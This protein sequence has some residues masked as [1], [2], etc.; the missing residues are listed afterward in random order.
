MTK[1]F[2]NLTSG[3]LSQTRRLDVVGNNMVNV[4]TP[5]YKAET[6]TDI[7]FEDV[8]ISRIGNANK[9]ESEVI[10]SQSY[11]LASDQLYVDMQNSGFELTGLNLD[12]ALLGDGFFG[13]QTQDGTEYTRGGSFTLDQEGYL[14][15]PTHGRVLGVNG[16]PIQLST[17]KITTDNYGRI[18]SEDTGA[19]LGQ[20]G[21]FDFADKSLMM[22]NESGLFNTGGQAPTT[23]ETPIMWKALESSNVDL[24]S[25]MSRMMTAQRALQ[26]S[27]QILKLYDELLTK[28]TTEIAR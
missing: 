23:V 20:I 13:V 9:D 22:K 26:S 16:Q 28:S 4:T 27:A 24:A 1:G 2:Y 6:Y 17:D 25:E 19:L 7:T 21:V 8:L 11:I 14:T 3:M 18:F 5:G 12:F 10:G 15:S